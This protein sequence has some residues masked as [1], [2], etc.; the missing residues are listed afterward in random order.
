MTVLAG[1]R[2]LDLSLFQS[3][4]IC[5]MLLGDMGAEVVR[6]E[7]PDRAPDRHWGLLGPDG[8]SLSYKLFGR[9]KK[10]ITLRFERPEGKGILAELVK[11]SDVVLHSFSPGSHKGKALSYKRLRS[12]NHSIVV[13]AI[14]DFGQN[15]PD[16]RLLGS[17]YTAQARS[18]G[19]TR[20][21][22]LEHGSPNASI[23]GGFAAA[24]H[25]ALGVVMA[26]YHREITG[27][28]QLIDISVFDA[29][30]FAAQ[31]MRALVPYE[32]LATHRQAGNKGFFP[33]HGC[34]EAR[35]GWVCLSVTTNGMWKR[36]LNAINRKDL[37]SNPRLMR[38]D[39]IRSDKAGEIGQAIAEW[40]LPRG[41][42]AQRED[43]HPET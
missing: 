10:G 40:L 35:D 6:I 17:D 32:D 30:L 34:F 39:G 3:G 8:E 41:L 26:L 31:C 33:Y 18:G 20:N 13:A 9:N 7:P 23:S 36:L 28:G 1:I 37:A 16:S 25:A 38:D 4:P 5:G 14:S 27:K 19:M 21:G 42:S 15:G 43:D 12:T 11:R 24:T 2:V 22:L 29:A